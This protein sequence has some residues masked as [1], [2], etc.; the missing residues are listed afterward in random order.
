M[1]DLL[2]E[3]AF[4]KDNGRIYCK[5]SG[6]GCAYQYWCDM[7]VKFKQKT[8]ALRCL[9]REEHGKRAATGAVS[10]DKV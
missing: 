10:T 1:S 6:M 2:C 4:R 5:V 3:K 9:G 7:A 8:G